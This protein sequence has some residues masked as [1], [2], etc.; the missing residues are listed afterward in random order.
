M[1]Q[2]QEELICDG[3]VDCPF[4]EGTFGATKDSADAEYNGLTHTIPVCDTFRD[5][6]PTAFVSAANAAIRSLMLDPLMK[7]SGSA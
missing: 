1:T 7:N 2:D 3:A 5:M 4:C 6:E